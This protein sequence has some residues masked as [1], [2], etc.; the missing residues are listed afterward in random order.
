MMVARSVSR[1][2][3]ADALPSYQKGAPSEHRQHATDASY[4]GCK[5]YKS[6]RRR[7]GINFALLASGLLAIAL[8][9]AACVA[10]LAVLHPNAPAPSGNGDGAA[11]TAERLLAESVAAAAAAKVATPAAAAQDL[12]YAPQQQQQQQ[13]EERQANDWLFSNDGRVTRGGQQP[14]PRSRRRL[15]LATHN[16]LFWYYYQTQQVRRQRV[17]L[18]AAKAFLL[19]YR[20]AFL[21]SQSL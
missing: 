10:L 14:A 13:Q 20:L 3:A 11:K 12:L 7:H 6:K 1:A 5:T 8:V 9:A 18:S 15:L 16:R 21:L 2:A 4:D 17:S 19:P